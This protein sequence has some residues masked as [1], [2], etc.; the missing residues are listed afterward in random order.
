MRRMILRMIAAGSLSAF[1]A[2][3]LQGS[4][5]ARNAQSASSARRTAR[6]KRASAGAPAAQGAPVLASSLAQAG[7]TPP[8]GSLLDIFV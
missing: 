3:V 6:G 8:R 4:S 1:S 5:A 7:R 2:S